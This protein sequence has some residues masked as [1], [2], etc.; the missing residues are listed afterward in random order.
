LWI[1]A[2]KKSNV[3]AMAVRL[4]II[5]DGDPSSEYV[6]TFVQDRIVIGRSRS[7]DICLPDMAVSTRHAEIRIKGTE[8][9]LMDLESLNGSFVND[10]PVLSFQQRR[11][12]SGDTIQVAGFTIRVALGVGPG[13]DEPRDASVRQAREMLSRLSART[14]IS[15][16]TR[17]FVVTAGPCRSMRISIS[18]GTPPLVLGRGSDSDVVLDDRDVSRSHAEIAVGADTVTI[19]D[20]GSKNGVVVNGE[21]VNSFQLDFG[22]S[23][24]IGK[25]TLVLEHPAESVLGAI[26]E[27][28]EEETS[29]FALVSRTAAVSFNGAHFESA[30][31][32][33]EQM[34]F[35]E[36]D[37]AD[38]D[39]TST[40]QTVS[41]GPADPLVGEVEAPPDWQTAERPG[42]PVQKTG[43][44]T[45]LGLI[46]IGII[47]LLAATAGLAYLFQ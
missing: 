38:V 32:S 46:V 33:S 15:T 47:L 36:D 17:T 6:R 16:D 4:T 21:R 39:A 29:S 7:S 30:S 26:F 14:G 37:S 24:T 11:L 12:H 10:K 40:P 41:V 25:S 9:V 23:F 22:D 19:R 3:T 2:A 45:D 35:T 42:A 43:Q 44:S 34:P 13:P 31:L 28:P 20:L 1:S 8:F 5:E 27:A 18:P